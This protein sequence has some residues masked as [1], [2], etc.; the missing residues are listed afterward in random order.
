LTRLRELRDAVL[1]NPDDDDARLVYADALLEQ[2][3]R[4]GELIQ[5]QVSLA[6]DPDQPALMKREDE[7]LARRLP[8]A[9]GFRRGMKEEAFM[10]R[11]I[12]REL[13][14]REPIRALTLTRVP[15]DDVLGAT[16]LF[17]RIEELRLTEP[18]GAYEIIRAVG[19]KK[20]RHLSI[21]GGGEDVVRELAG[22]LRDLRSLGLTD[23][24][25]YAERAAPLGEEDLEELLETLPSLRS[26]DLMGRW[27]DE[28]AA[29]LIA[30]R[31]ISTLAEAALDADDLL[32]VD[33]M[34]GLRALELYEVDAGVV[35]WFEQLERLNVMLLTGDVNGRLASL[36]PGM[37][38]R[39]R[40][41]TF[42]VRPRAP[43]EHINRRAIVAPPRGRA[44][45]RQA[46]RRPRRRRRPRAARRSLP[47]VLD[48]VVLR[49]RPALRL[50]R[51]DPLRHRR[52]RPH[53]LRVVGLRSVQRDPVRTEPHDDR[54]VHAVRDRP[55]PEQ[56]LTRRRVRPRVAPD[57]AHAIDVRRDLR[58]DPT[59]R[60]RAAPDVHRHRRPQRREPR[61]HLGGDRARLRPVRRVAWPQLGGGEELRQV[62]ADRQRVPHGQVRVAQDRHAPGRRPRVDLRPR[63]LLIE[64]DHDLVERRARRVHREPAAHRPRRVVLVTDD[65]L[66][67]VYPRGSSIFGSSG[68]GL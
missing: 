6:R 32:V 33:H 47:D 21:E 7:L 67:H 15:V 10:S 48:G 29:P 40:E 36:R 18:D 27:S 3:V 26:L 31:H 13:L 30:W 42:S 41:L 23:E 59:R 22:E 68:S 53:R 14:A 64:R 5:V 54:R 17:G 20:L 57:R 12:D 61:V 45:D 58:R 66:Q 19:P 16:S 62:L 43:A 49:H 28:L 25:V 52:V 65:D 8:R 34:R 24:P 1:A 4:D 51:R 9:L 11:R 46:A 50:R 63:V 37:F 39:L 56:V 44:T 35:G 55:P 2:G 38:P 60:R